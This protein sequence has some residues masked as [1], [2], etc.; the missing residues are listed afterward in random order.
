MS[1]T[2]GKKYFSE[3]QI[4]RTLE[5]SRRQFEAARRPNYRIS[6]ERILEALAHINDAADYDKIIWRVQQSEDSREYFDME[7]LAGALTSLKMYYSLEVIDGKNLHSLSKT[8]DVFWHAHQDFTFDYTAFCEKVFGPG[9]FLHHLPLDQRSE[10][11]Q[12]VIARRYEYTRTMIDR[13]Y[14]IDNTFWGDGLPI[15][16]SYESPVA[17]GFIY[18]RPALIAMEPACNIYNDNALNIEIQKKT[19]L[20]LDGFAAL[21]S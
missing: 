8:L 13:V 17:E 4:E 6:D 20:V 14:R 11:Q 15:C 21:A 1:K 18:W 3:D 16:C 19:N 9:Q 2:N 10:E 7:Y 12:K 5:M